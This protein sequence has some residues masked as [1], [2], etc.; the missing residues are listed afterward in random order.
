VSIGS[1]FLKVSGLTSLASGDLAVLE[2][3]Q[4]VPMLINFWAAW[5]QP[6]IK[7]A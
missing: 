3:S 1:S 4:G 5:C 6:S 7:H 2:H